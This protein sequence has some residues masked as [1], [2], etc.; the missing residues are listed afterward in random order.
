MMGREKPTV[1]DGLMD[2]NRLSKDGVRRK[3]RLTL[4]PAL[5]RLQAQIVKELL[6]VLRDP[7]SR[8]VLVVPP[9]I[10]LFVFAF[11]ATLEIR[12]IDIALMNRDAGGASV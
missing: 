1:K 2:E 10:Q 11:A 4:P 6:C 7:K 5:Q 12:N 8:F 9:L 3:T